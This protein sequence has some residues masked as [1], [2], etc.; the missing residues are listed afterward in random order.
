[1][2]TVKDAANPESTG[3]FKKWSMQLWGEVAD[4]NDAP[5]W[6]PAAA[7]EIDEEE[8]G[9][10]TPTPIPQKPKPTA[11]LPTEHGGSLPESLQTSGA[12]ATA[13][14]GS[15]ETDDKPDT[16]ASA[17]EGVFDGIDTLRKHSTWLGGAILIVLIAALGVGGFFLVRQRRRRA[18]LMGMS[19]GEAS[20]GNYAPVADDDVPMSL[21][22][23]G[24]RA[25]GMGHKERDGGEESKELYDAFGD[26]PSDSEDEEDRE[27][28]RYHDDFLADDDE[29][30]HPHASGS[31]RRSVEADPEKRSLGGDVTPPRLQT[32][33]HDDLVGA[34]ESNTSSGSWQDAAD[35]VRQ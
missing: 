8:T 28:L 9:S 2:I 26:G 21:M 17:D 35:D 25:V 22:E 13:P 18:R 12:F 31:G 24:R 6:S 5:L 4:E 29:H 7:G 27:G 33:S 11:L 23:R 20:R 10:P 34:G 14:H 1:V 32:P 15:A 3:R 19:G 30:H 16:H